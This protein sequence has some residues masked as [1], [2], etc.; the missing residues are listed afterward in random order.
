MPGEARSTDRAV[1]RVRD[2]PE[3]PSSRGS[4]RASIE[5]KFTSTEKVIATRRTQHESAV[6]RWAALIAK[7]A[8]VPA[9]SNP[10]DSIAYCIKDRRSVAIRDADPVVLSNGRRRRGQLPFMWPN[11]DADRDCLAPRRRTRSLCGGTGSRRRRL[12]AVVR[13]SRVKLA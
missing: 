6:A 2:L 3:R 5:V 4:K 9:A 12:P 7:L 8:R 11:G 10:P 13:A 1:E